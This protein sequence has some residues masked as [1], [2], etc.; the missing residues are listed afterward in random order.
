[1]EGM[2][3]IEVSKGSIIDIYNSMIDLSPAQENEIYQKAT[4][5]VDKGYFTGTLEELI[6]KMRDKLLAELNK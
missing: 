1:M 5:L 2:A 3:D 4:Y 6:K